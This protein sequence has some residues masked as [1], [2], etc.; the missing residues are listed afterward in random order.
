MHEKLP[1]LYEALAIAQGQ[2]L[3][4]A[5]NR[6]V[7]IKPRDS[8]AYTFRFA[9]LEAIITATRQAL[10]S[11][12]LAI[13]QLVEPNTGTEY[14]PGKRYDQLVTKLLHKDGAHIEDRVDLPSPAAYADPKQYAGDRTYLRRY[15]R[16]SLLD[17]AADDDLDVDGK[18]LGE[19]NGFSTREPMGGEQGD[20]RPAAR[21]SAVARNLKA[22]EKPR[23]PAAELQA[24]RDRIKATRTDKDVLALWREIGP[25]LTNSEDHA[26]VGMDM[27]AHRRSLKQPTPEH[28]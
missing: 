28:A 6:T 13:V 10:S 22:G 1:A 24:Y 15:A 11:N 27:A 5:K 25:L 7:V 26:A 17:V 14:E 2:F 23:I 9:D 16:S 20:E 12:G 4:I 3:P 19:G 21:S 8:A 18:G